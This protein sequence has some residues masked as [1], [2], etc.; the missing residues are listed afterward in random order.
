MIFLESFRTKG[1]WHLNLSLRSDHFCVRSS[2]CRRTGRIA[3]IDTLSDDVL[4][5]IFDQV[6]Q[7]N[8]RWNHDGWFTLTHTCRRW[9]SI[10]FA[11]PLR[12]DLQLRCERGINVAEMLPHAPPLPIML[13]YPSRHWAGYGDEEA[14]MLALRH[15]RARIRTINFDIPTNIQMAVT[16]RI[17][18]RGMSGPFPILEK[19]IFTKGRYRPGEPCRLFPSTFSAP[20]LR[21]LH[22]SNVGDVFVP[23]LPLF[24]RAANLTSLHLSGII[25]TS[26]LPVGLLAERLALMPQLDNFYLLFHDPTNTSWHKDQVNPRR[27][28]VTLPVLRTFFFQGEGSYMEELAASISTPRLGKLNATFFNEPFYSLAHFKQLLCSIPNFRLPVAAV[29]FWY[30][31]IRL[32]I[33]SNEHGLQVGHSELRRLS[34]PFNISIKTRP[35]LVRETTAFCAALVP[36]LSSVDVLRLHSQPLLYP[37]SRPDYGVDRTTWHNLLRP[38]VSVKMLLLESAALVNEVSAVLQPLE[39]DANGPSSSGLLPSLRK[40]AWPSYIDTGDAFVPLIK[41]RAA[42]QQPI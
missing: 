8:N 4:L 3:A 2:L 5:E 17:L 21:H 1:E 19:L 9:R 13:Y 10:V 18:L 11:S 34:V 12:L 41:E 20:R 7:V 39:D 33:V 32:S 28:P 29:E 6:R 24:A 36:L 40:I 25:S 23:G 38:F 22:L 35:F 27:A 26:L 30:D 15:Y 37:P 14:I 42:N 31:H 16:S